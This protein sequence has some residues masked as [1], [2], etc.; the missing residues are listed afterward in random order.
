MQDSGESLRKSSSSKILVIILIII[1]AILFLFIIVMVVFPAIR[2][3]SLFGF[4]IRSAFSSQGCVYLFP[5]PENKPLFKESSETRNITSNIV[6]KPENSKNDVIQANTFMSSTIRPSKIFNNNIEKNNKQTF[7]VYVDERNKFGNLLLT[8][9]SNNAS[10]FSYKDLLWYSGKNKIIIREKNRKLF[11]RN[12]EELNR[13]SED[14]K[15]KYAYWFIEKG[16]IWD[17]ERNNVV[18]VIN[19]IHMKDGYKEIKYFLI[20]SPKENISPLETGWN[21]Y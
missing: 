13:M 11:V 16:T 21:F 8:K 2:C 17:Y 15:K 12:I 4:L 9:D 5:P 3:P 1:I 19:Y 10:I 6:P 20:M 7:Y 18:S 14:D